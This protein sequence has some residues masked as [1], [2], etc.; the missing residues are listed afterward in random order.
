MKSSIVLCGLL[1]LLSWATPQLAHTQ[2]L[3]PAQQARIAYY[4]LHVTPT[5]GQQRRRLEQVL[6]LSDKQL[7]DSIHVQLYAIRRRASLLR[8]PLPD[9]SQPIVS[10]TDQQQLQQLP[11]QVKQA[12]TR[13]D[14]LLTKHYALLAD[15]AQQLAAEKAFWLV[16]LGK[17]PPLTDKS[18]ATDQQ[19]IN[20]QLSPAVLLLSAAPSVN[21][22]TK[23]PS[24]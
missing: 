17:L 3:T 6:S 11:Q 20:H 15:I 9:G 23:R 10:E 7:L 8:D 21:T 22:T 12:M 1:I 14:P 2:A 5:I 19:L 16:K 24:R 4:R 13:L 18:L